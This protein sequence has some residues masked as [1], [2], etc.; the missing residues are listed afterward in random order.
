MRERRRRYVLTVLQRATQFE[1]GPHVRAQA[2]ALLEH[3]VESTC[4]HARCVRSSRRWSTSQG[5]L[6]SVLDRSVDRLVPEAVIALNNVLPKQS[7][8]AA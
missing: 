1:H 7:L 5:A 6:V 2:I 3:L 8:Y 4:C